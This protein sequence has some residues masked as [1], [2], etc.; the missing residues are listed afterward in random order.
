MNIRYLFKK[1]NRSCNIPKKSLLLPC[2]FVRCFWMTSIGLFYKQSTF[3]FSQLIENIGDSGGQ[4]VEIKSNN[5]FT[6]K[7]FYKITL[8]LSLTEKRKP[9]R[10]KLHEEMPQISIPRVFEVVIP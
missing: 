7:Y 8:G 9:S 4:N 3:M 6:I 1:L 2:H 10:P 5:L